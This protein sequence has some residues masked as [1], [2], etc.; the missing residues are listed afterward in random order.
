[1]Q[2]GWSAR[3]VGDVV[4]MLAMEEGADFDALFEAMQENNAT[5]VISQIMYE[6]QAALV[7]RSMKPGMV[8]LDIGCGPSLAYKNSS[9]TFLIGVDLSLAALQRNATAD[10]AFCASAT[11]LP[12]ANQSV[13]L[14]VCFYSI[15]HMVGDH[16]SKTTANVNKAFSEFSRIIKPDGTL[17]IFEVCPWPMFGM[18]QKFLWPLARRILG[19]TVNYYFWQER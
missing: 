6:R 1:M 9:N 19:K 14:I 8:I 10:L 4:D 11:A 17:L 2:C 16:I 18:L 13:D 12:L 3:I 15:H 7:E 5:S